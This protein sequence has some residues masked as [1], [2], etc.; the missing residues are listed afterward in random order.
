MEPTNERENWLAQVSE[1]ILEPELPIIDAHHHL[2][3][4]RPEYRFPRYLIDEFS[5]DLA[6]G[7]NF[8]AT[9]YVE[10][11]TMFRCHGPEAMRCVGE[12]EFVVGLS[13]MSSS[14]LYGEAR[15]A[16]AIVARQICALARGSAKCWMHKSRRLVEGFAACEWRNLAPGR[17]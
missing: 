15:V 3:D 6:T 4:R 14:G 9:V 7:H 13:A 5:A 1:P 10:N 2:W 11:G 17:R 12:T 16:P 8:V